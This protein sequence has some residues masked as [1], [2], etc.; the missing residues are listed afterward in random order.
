MEKL[1]EAQK[2]GVKKM[3]T[4]RLMQKLMSI[5]MSEEEVSS[6][7]REGLLEAWAHAIVEGKDVTTETHALATDKSVSGYDVELEGRK[8]AFEMQK[9]EE[10]RQKWEE[11]RKL[12]MRR[13]DIEERKLKSAEESEEY[14]RREIERVEVKDEEERR[15]LNSP[16][17]KAKLFSDALRG[18][19]LKMP[20]DAIDL[21]AYFR[22]V[23][24]LFSDFSVEPSLRAH[25]LKPHLSDKARTLISRMSPEKS[26]DYG[27]VKQLLLH[28]FK[29][30]SSALLQKY[31]SLHRENDETFML[32]GNRLKSV[33][34]YYTE[35][36][37]VRDFDN[38]I[39]L[40]VCD[41]IKSQL[42]EAVLKYIVN[43]ENMT[44][45]GW[46]K[47][48]ELMEALDTYYTTL[49]TFDKPLGGNSLCLNSNNTTGPRSNNYA[50]RSQSSYASSRFNGS[51]YHS[52][53]NKFRGNDDMK[54]AA[55]V[56]YMNRKKCYVCG[57]TQHLA[58]YHK[59][60]LSSNVNACHATNVHV[61]SSLLSTTSETVPTDG[62]ICIPAPIPSRPI[63][64]VESRMTEHMA[65][66]ICVD[67]TTSDT[68]QIH[69]LVVDKPNKCVNTFTA[70]A[71]T[72]END[73][74]TLQY[75]DVCLSD[76]ISKCTVSALVDSG[77]EI[78]LVNSAI[79]KDWNVDKV[80]SIN[81]RG[82]VGNPI[83][84]DVIRVYI[85]L[86]YDDDISR[87]ISVLM[88]VSPLVNDSLILNTEVINKLVDA[89][90]ASAINTVHT[91]NDE[92]VSDQEDVDIEQKI[93]QDVDAKRDDSSLDFRS[94]TTDILYNEQRDDETL[95]IC[96]R[97]AMQSK[98]GY[99][100]K[101]KLLF[102]TEIIM[103]QRCEQLILPVSRR[104]EVMKLAHD[105]YG[106]HMGARNT[107]QRIKY[108]FFWPTI[109]S[110]V[111]KY[112]VTCS[113]CARRQRITC[114]DNTPVT[115]IQRNEK[116]FNHWHIDA[117]G[118]IHGSAKADVNFCLVCVDSNTRFPMAFALRSLTARNIAD[119]LLKLW[120]LFGV[121][122]FVTMDNASC[123]TAKL[124]RLLMER[125]GCSPIFITPTNSRANGLAERYIGTI[126]EL[127]HKVA[128][129]KQKS[130]WKYLDLIMWALRE[131]PQSSSATPPWML[132]FG[133][134]P[135]GPCAILKD[136]WT[137][138]ESLP[139]DLAPTTTEYLCKLRERIA[140]VN[141]YATDCMNR[142]QYKWASRYNKRTRP[143]SFEIGDSVLILIPDSTTSRLWSR[144]RAPA[145]IV[146][147]KS[148]Y[149][150]IVEYEGNRHCLP[151]SKIRSYDVRCESV[152]CNV[153][154]NV[155]VC[156]SIIYD[157]DVEFGHI[158]Y[159]D[160]PLCANDIGLPSEKIPDDKLD[161]LSQ[162]QKL[163]L[164]TLLDEY[165]DLFTDKPGLCNLYEHEIHVTPEFK[166]K[167]LKEYQIPEKLRGEVSKQIKELLQ[168]GLIRVS[169]SPMASPLICTL[170]G[171]N[172]R[173]GVRIVMDYRFLNRY[174]ISDALSPPDIS[175]VI[176][177]IGRAKFI[178]TF[179]GK[180]S[181]WTIP[182]KT[183]HQWLT[184]FVCD[185]QTYEWTRAAFGLKN[186]GCTFLRTIERVLQPVRDVVENFVDDMAVCTD[187]TWDEH[188]RHMSVFLN[189]IRKSGLTLSL[190]KSNFVKPEVKF[191]GH[192]IGSGKRRIDPEKT[193]SI[194]QLKRPETK[195]Q[196]RSVL[197]TFSWFRDYIPNF[198]DHVRPLIELT[199]KRIPD[200]IPWRCEHDKSFNT[201]KSLLCEATKRSLSIID[202][203]KPFNIYSDASDFSISGVLTQT[204]KNGNDYP[205]AFYS[206]KLSDSQKVWPI[207]EREAYAV[208][209]ALQR[210]KCWI[211]C[212]PINVWCDHNPLSYLTD[213]TPKSPRLLRW[214]LAL[215]A[216]DLSFHYKSGASSAMAAADCL[217]RMGPDESNC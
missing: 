46:L 206:K 19:M 146:D 1:T 5:G 127:I 97:L 215:Q 189:T 144:W 61:K 10:E 6:L 183:E 187:T 84:A 147:K 181:Y 74:S 196:V 117:M 98:G 143:K 56:S 172:G 114:F 193:A 66:A 20:S 203:S 94:A 130:W 119:C 105:T 88:A 213:T 36:R 112:V 100:Y 76:S 179:D 197:G 209:E 48:N 65:N 167:R 132:A 64:N 200:R 63:D 8:L 69:E 110:D 54:Y 118:P 25:L 101:N 45:G 13:L 108:S 198:T 50:N 31:E 62:V 188:L 30:N 175:T 208:L 35:S 171:P 211:F 153:T 116:S 124:T 32:Y 142:A 131:V 107:K 22:S 156:T 73:F 186:S 216:Y 210:F 202:W 138:T 3:S 154:A 59:S 38:L 9:W 113:V 26:S 40:L 15:R 37:K 135:R 178:S 128:C 139:L 4:V 158:D 72:V 86:G 161:H 68:A 28:E 159:V 41:R 91:D 214:A 85:K 212:Y 104:S 120:S 163:Q 79:V 195:K 33:F 134:L 12:E 164:L 180:S 174:T 106:A 149:S 47:F 52:T 191:C 43:M 152:H 168:L 27:E 90:Q 133:H 77:A 49:K 166:P 34:M 170:K 190:K 165:A 75:I 92:I 155:N 204:D 157:K 126:K 109:A 7:N 58:N 199:S 78:S 17:Y 83:E 177:R 184:G 53:N 148:A 18:T 99:Y 151:V 82:I 21:I 102:R 185:G 55:G 96:H 123:N 125:M 176:Q 129:D 24:R 192:I 207:I 16:V 80:G 29:L 81:L 95:N 121:S 115:P 205:I 162:F 70:I 194:Q 42:P 103:G 11:E 137:G 141:E 93:D 87:Y 150:Y 169:T 60:N 136:H 39:D 14:K 201:L 2:A 182:I 217:S 160:I 23:E 71:K 44:D 111:R 89:S 57:S 122:Q 67:S 145:T 140:E 51:S 173:D